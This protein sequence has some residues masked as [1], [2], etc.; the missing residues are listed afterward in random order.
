MDENNACLDD[1]KSCLVKI[2]SANND[3]LQGEHGEVHDAVTHMPVLPQVGAH[4]DDVT[5]PRMVSY[6]DPTLPVAAHRRTSRASRL[7]PS[8]S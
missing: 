8:A 4:P 3:F 2:L 1:T 7:R 6:M 5:G